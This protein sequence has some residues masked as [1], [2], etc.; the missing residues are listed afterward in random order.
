MK[1]AFLHR[2]LGWAEIAE[3]PSVMLKLFSLRSD[4]IND[5]MTLHAAVQK[6]PINWGH[7]YAKSQRRQTKDCRFHVLA[8]TKQ[9]VLY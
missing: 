8:P 6:S 5:I 9:C 1:V 3:S 2:C 7:Q 4:W